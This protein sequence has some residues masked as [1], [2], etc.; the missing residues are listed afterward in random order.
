[1]SDVDEECLREAKNIATNEI[2]LKH[3]IVFDING[4]FSL[5]REV[6][7]LASKSR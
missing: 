4:V 7:C 1:M 2:G 5:A 6:G 3:S